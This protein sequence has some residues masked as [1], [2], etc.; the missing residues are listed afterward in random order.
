MNDSLAGR[1]VLVTGGGKGIGAAIARKLA[2]LGATTI[3]CGR[4][5]ARLEQ[6][7]N[8]ASCESMVCDG[9]GG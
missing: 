1:A 8:D 4:N 5:R 3:I 2:G 6:T 9:T 7:A